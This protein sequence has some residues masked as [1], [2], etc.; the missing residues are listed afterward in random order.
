LTDYWLAVCH[1]SAS[2]PATKPANWSEV[3]LTDTSFNLEQAPSRTSFG[4]NFFLGDYEGLA[5]AGNDFVAVWG[6]PDGSAAEQ[7]S[8]FF[9]RAI[10]TSGNSSSVA[11]SAGSALIA[12]FPP[13]TAAAWGAS[14]S[15]HVA[16]I[17]AYAPAPSNPST[18]ERAFIDAVRLPELGA[19]TLL[20]LQDRVWADL[21]A[22]LYLNEWTF[23][24][25]AIGTR[26]I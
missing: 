12:A 19:A 20:H 24:G 21:E 11:M 5:A 3:R 15:L 1:P 18:D 7:E 16:G 6:M 23:N 2:A 17:T 26:A 14:D 10:S 4:S 13:Q 22:D 25:S 8:I 9:R